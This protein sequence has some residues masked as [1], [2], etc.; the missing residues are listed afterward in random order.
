VEVPVYD[1][2][3]LE[4]T[5]FCVNLIWRFQSDESFMGVFNADVE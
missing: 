3:S 2:R 5:R 4:I 1:D